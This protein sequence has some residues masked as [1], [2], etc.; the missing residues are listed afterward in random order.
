MTKKVEQPFT[1]ITNQ[2]SLL[3]MVLT[4]GSYIALNVFKVYNYAYACIIGLACSFLAFILN[5]LQYNLLARLAL[6]LTFCGLVFFYSLVYGENSSLEFFFVALLGMVFFLF[7]FDDEKIAITSL[8]SLILIEWGILYLN[9]FSLFELAQIEEHQKKYIYAIGVLSLITVIV[10]QLFNYM[11]GQVKYFNKI[12]K[13]KQQALISSEEKTAFLNTMSHEIRTPLNAINGLSFILKKESPETHQINEINQIEQDGKRL[14]KLLNNVLDYSKYQTYDVE[15][16]KTPNT[17]LKEL[18]E[19]TTLYKKECAEK[20]IDFQLSVDKN[21]PTVFIDLKKFLNVIDNLF[22]NALKFTTSGCITLQ[23]KKL[24]STVNTKVK[25]VVI[26]KDTGLGM[27]ARKKQEILNKNNDIYSLIKNTNKTNIGLGIP[28]LKHMLLL[29]NSEISVESKLGEGSSFSFELVL[30]KAATKSIPTATK[31]RAGNKILVV[32]DNKVNLLVARQIL[33]KENFSVTE[34]SNGEEAVNKMKNE[35]FDLV[36]M[37][38]QMPI[39]DGFKA[40]KEIRVFDKETPIFALS[41]SVLS[42]LTEEIKFYGFNGL[43]LKPFDPKKL[44][45][46][47]K[48][49]IGHG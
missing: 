45:A 43:I 16:E 33:E 13:I 41:A 31:I 29:M 42:D 32:D 26:L 9:N 36:L 8:S 4:I 39:L 7:S 47:L 11:V 37:D 35:A 46:T 40:T 19:V 48:T 10:F 24:K 18:N 1:E 20:N 22:Y 15:L 3:F 6:I 14:I 49:T 23:V 44:I 17:I 34:A 5:R 12:K 27:S 21:I 2:L 28:L 38:I 30:D 25:L